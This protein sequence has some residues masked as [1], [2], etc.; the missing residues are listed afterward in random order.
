MC[1]LLTKALPRLARAVSAQ[2]CD[3]DRI[4]CTVTELDN[5]EVIAYLAWGSLRS[6]QRTRLYTRI[7][8]GKARAMDVVSGESSGNFGQLLLLYPLLFWLQALQA[9][10]G[11]SM[12]LRGYGALFSPE[13]WLVRRMPGS[14][15]A[16]TA[17]WVWV[18]LSEG[19]AAM[20]LPYGVTMLHIA[21][22]WPEQKP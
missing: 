8:L 18:R 4:A 19:S 15:L 7:A 13:G 10:I 9:N 22:T 1:L 12:M 2:S 5:R 6:Y 11:V 21:A 14:G 20:Y 17:C 16:R 3:S